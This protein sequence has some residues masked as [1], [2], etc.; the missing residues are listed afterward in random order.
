VTWL[1]FHGRRRR[2]RIYGEH[3]IDLEEH[4]GQRRGW[5]S[6][7][8]ELDARK[9]VKRYKTF[10]ATWQPAGGTIRVV[11]VDEPAGWVAFFCTGSATTAADILGCV[12]D[13]SS[14]ENAQPDY[15]S[16]RRW[17]CAGRIGYHRRDGVARTGRVVP[18]APGRP[19]RRIRMP[20][21]TRRA[22]PPRA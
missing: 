6:G 12:A 11:L 20:D 16:R 21:T 19:H 8:F 9:A 14:L 1:G 18:A 2:P 13:R 17:V 22:T 7:A 4:T 15:P 3:R 10:V 5:A